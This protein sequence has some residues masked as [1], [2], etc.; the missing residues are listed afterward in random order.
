MVPG[1]ICYEGG[2]TG[3]QPIMVQGPLLGRTSFTVT[4]PCDGDRHGIMDIASQ[5]QPVEQVG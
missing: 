4:G 3:L 5:H 2:P 1:I